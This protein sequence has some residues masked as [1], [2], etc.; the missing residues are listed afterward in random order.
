[1]MFAQVVDRLERRLDVHRRVP[2]KLGGGRIDD[3]PIELE[4]AVVLGIEQLVV[5][6][7]EKFA[8]D[9][10]IWTFKLE[11]DHCRCDAAC[12]REVVELRI[13]SVIV[14][15]FVE[16][17]PDLVAEFARTHDQRRHSSSP[18]PRSHSVSF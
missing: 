7:L 4:P 10:G 16:L 3:E 17:T 12:A 14:E 15:G 18:F 6:V 1:M 2:A 11:G 8:Q 5:L 13:R 9:Q